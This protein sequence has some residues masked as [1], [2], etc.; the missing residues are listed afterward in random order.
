VNFTGLFLVLDFALVFAQQ[1]ELES[2][3][4]V[5]VSFVQH[6]EMVLGAFAESTAW[7]LP[8]YNL[9]GLVRGCGWSALIAARGREMSLR[10]DFCKLGGVLVA[11]ATRSRA[12]AVSRAVWWCE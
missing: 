9:A 12:Q 8:G 10:A 6:M 11:A 5:I 4:G 2:I 3:F 1:E 7:V